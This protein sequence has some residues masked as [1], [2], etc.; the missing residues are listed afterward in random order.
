[1]LSVLI[2]DDEKPARVVLATYLQELPDVRVVGEAENGRLAVQMAIA[3]APDLVLLD[4]EMPD[5][6]GI[7]TAAQL[8]PSTAIIFVTAYDR[9]A[10][11]AFELHAFDYILKPVM[12]DRLYEAI[13]HVQALRQNPTQ[14][15][16]TAPSPHQDLA[17]LL[18]FF[19]SR[20]TYLSRITIRSN[21]E[22]LILSVFDISCIRIENSSVFVYSRS[23]KY[24]HDTS[25]K[26][27]EQRL[28]PSIFLRIHRSTLVNKNHIKRIITLAKGR[29]AVET[30]DHLTLP[31][32][33]DFL[34]PL[35]ISIGWDISP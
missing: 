13:R 8:S 24:L 33:R 25:L 15:R 26:T 35:K 1:M 7:E 19:R 31:I 21:F 30:T 3:L 17:E 22:Y 12:K 34:A 5:L 18:E 23:L 20:Q 29:Y 4:V 6:N 27:L 10:I 32:S 16:P 11:K 28:D 2:V 9:Y 14:P